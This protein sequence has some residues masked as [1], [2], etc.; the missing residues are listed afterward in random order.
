[1]EPSVLLFLAFFTGFLLLLIRGQ[2]KAYGRLPPGPRP[3]PF[4]GNLLQMDR[5]GF[6]KSFIQLCDKHGDVFTVHLGPRPVI[7]LYGTETIK[8]ALVDYAEAF[9]GR[10]TIAVI[11]PIIQDYGEIWDRVEG[12]K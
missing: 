12:R 7:M 1:M 6:L 10:G 8:E 4:L 5:G 9:S 3:L 2:P 11:Q